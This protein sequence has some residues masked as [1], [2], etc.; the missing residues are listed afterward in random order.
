MDASQLNW[1]S[2]TDAARAIRDGA[3]SAEQLVQACLARVREVE[4]QVQAWH[5]LDPEHAL[6]QAGARSTSAAAKAR[7]SGR[8]TACQSA[9]RTSSTPPTCR[10]RTARV[11]H[12]GRTPVADATVVAMLRPRAR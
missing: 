5:F 2:A 3:I 12:A 8:C 11:L 4:P 7:R 9:S 6:A 1:L 10:P